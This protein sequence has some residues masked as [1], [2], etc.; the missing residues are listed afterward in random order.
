MK[1]RI[2]HAKWQIWAYPSLLV[3]GF[4]GT[5]V[6]A[7]NRFLWYA[8]FLGLYYVFHILLILPHEWGHAFASRLQERKVFRITVGF[9]RT[10]AKF[11]IFGIPTEFKQYPMGGSTLSGPGNR[12]HY[13]LQHAITVMGGP[14]MNL[15]IGAAAFLLFLLVAASGGGVDPPWIGA[16]WNQPFWTSTLL[17]LLVTLAF[18]SLV[19]L[20]SNLWPHILRTPQGPIPNDGMQL[21]KAPFLKLDEVEKQL[22]GRY[23]GVLNEE[24]ADAGD[25]AR[26]REFFKAVLIVSPEDP[27]ILSSYGLLLLK[28]RDYAGARALFQNLSARENLEPALKYLFLNNLAWADY[29][30]GDPELLKEADEASAQAYQNLFWITPI[31]GTRGAVLLALGR[32]EEAVPFLKEAL[33]QNQTAG[34][35]ALNA[36]ML[37]MAE[38]K[39]GNPEEARKYLELA[40][41]LDPDCAL[42][43]RA[44]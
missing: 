42:L 33:E 36:C 5:L 2:R 43:E 44:S 27:V 11:R 8:E 38:K 41:K 9:G 10:V 17:N 39:R 22:A 24:M 21:W 1:K 23:A 13:R 34:N 7:Q 28:E 14:A 18:T 26:A 31:K 35:Q 30:T 37:A 15:L 12:K 20:L 6:N 32:V 40:R 4:L 3:L 29:L 16:R 19:M 25:L